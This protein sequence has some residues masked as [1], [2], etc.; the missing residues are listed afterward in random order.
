M[1]SLT[2]GRR[3]RVRWIAWPTLALGL[4]VL[5]LA[6][7]RACAPVGPVHV[8]AVGD[9][10]CAPNDPKYNEGRGQDG[11]CRAQAVSDAAV[12]LHPDLV[13]GLGDYQYEVASAGDYAA[14]YAP[15]WGRLRD[16]TRPA[17]GNQELKVNKA[18][19][20]YGYFGD[21]ALPAPGYGSYDVGSW[22]VVVLNTNCT[23]VEGGC[24][25]ESPQVAWLQQDLAGN[26]GRCV[27]AY[28]HHPRWSNGIAGPDNRLDPL[29]A[30]MVRGGV[31]LYLSG[32]ESDYERFPPLDSAHQGD[33]NG[34]RQFVVGTGGQSLYEPSAGDASWRAT[35][36][37][38]PSEF[39]DATQN[40]FLDLTLGDGSYSWAFVTA[41][42]D[43]IDKGSE[44]CSGM[45]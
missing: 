20:Y 11:E 45:E 23:V 16:V 3:S 2:P 14:A 7:T 39:F 9:M 25:A 32:H 35:F 30:A 19:T 17:I 24:G 31:S 27:L 28:G 8:I 21:K 12:A 42:G 22:H 43:S 4:V 26:T 44:A 40:G 13:L 18:S 10:A 5:I 33:P 1:P 36:D 34:V 37:P 38:I 6:L 29:Y 41:S 15:T